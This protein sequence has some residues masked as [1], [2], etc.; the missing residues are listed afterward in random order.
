MQF[1]TFQQSIKHT[2]PPEDSTVYLSAMWHDGQG[3]WDKA[4]CMLG[5]CLSS[6]Q[7]RGSV[8]CR[9][10]VSK[11]R[12]KKTSY[13]FTGGMGDNCKSAAVISYLK[14][15]PIKSSPAIQ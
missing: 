7:G 10:L 8:E 6:P 4:H 5:A 1:E 13:Y 14:S 11:S 9:L 3:N 15:T 2:V 12:Q